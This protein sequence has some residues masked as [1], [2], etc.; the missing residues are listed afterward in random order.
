MPTLI[1]L[2][3][4]K[5][6]RGGSGILVSMSDAYRQDL[7]YLRFR[8][9]LLL[10]QHT[11]EGVCMLHECYIALAFLEPQTLLVTKI[12]NS[13]FGMLPN[14]FARSLTTPSFLQAC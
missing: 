12:V 7:G 9:G 6:V 3:A 5:R 13:T 4:S 8:V 14:T 2:N 1:T 11:I 10:S